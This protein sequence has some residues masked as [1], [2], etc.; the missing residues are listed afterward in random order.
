MRNV[1]IACLLPIAGA[2]AFTVW[3]PVSLAAAQGADTTATPNT[4]AAPVAAAPVATPETSATPATPPDTSAASSSAPAT[5]V[6]TPSALPPAASAAAPAS[7]PAAAAHAP[8]PAAAKPSSAARAQASATGT[9]AQ[10]KIK[11]PVTSAGCKAAAQPGKPYFV[12]F[13]SRTAASYGHTFVF[14]GRIGS[15]KGFASFKVAGL[16]PKGDDPAVYIQGHW[17]PVPA[18][19]GAS[20]GDLDEQYL[21]ARFCVPLT[22]A[23]YRRAEAYIKNLQATKTTWHATTYNCNSF[24]ADIARYIGLDTPNPN[25]YLPEAFIKRIEELNKASVRTSSPLA[26]SSIGRKTNQ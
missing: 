12:E 20:Y 14:H 19:T 24:G 11:E 17:I 10:E 7:S 21:T 26:N 5:S 8:R 6:A 2:V 18:E 22:E 16:H 3:L 25:M 1:V 4:T 15:G 9:T 23:E 13:R